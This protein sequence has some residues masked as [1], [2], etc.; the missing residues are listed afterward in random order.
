MIRYHK[1]DLENDLIETPALAG[2]FSYACGGYM[3]RTWLQILPS[4]AYKWF[5]RKECSV[6]HIDG[7]YWSQ[8]ASDIL[9]KKEPS[10]KVNI[11]L[12]LTPVFLVK[13][14]SRLLCDVVDVHGR[15]W[16]FPDT[17]TMIGADPNF[18]KKAS[19]KIDKNT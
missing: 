5:A 2:V 19:V 8:P 16:F 6:T 1:C 17:D 18:A 7:V 9:I 11:L 14:F 3:L 13:W 12:Q 10:E 15:E 4:F